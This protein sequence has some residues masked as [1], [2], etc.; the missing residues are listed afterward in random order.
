MF[1]HILVLCT[2]NICRSPVAEALLKKNLPDKHIE[3]AGLGALVDHP[4]DGNAAQLAESSG[5][6]VSHH[7]ARQLTSTMLKQ[8]EIVLVMTEAQRAHV[9]TL[10]A[11]ASGKTFILGHWL[12]GSPD[13]PDPYKKSFEAFEHVHNMLLDATNAWLPR[14]Q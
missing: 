7:R 9:R 11:T 12:P 8:A 5:L 4:V 1:D 13:I 3:S 14:L 6:D 10:D 2:G